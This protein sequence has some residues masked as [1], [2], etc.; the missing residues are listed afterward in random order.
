MRLPERLIDY[1]LVHELVHTKIPNH[2]PGFKEQL[3]RHFPDGAELDKSV[4]KFRPSV[5]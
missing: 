4:K 2:G 5:L 3:K 1:I